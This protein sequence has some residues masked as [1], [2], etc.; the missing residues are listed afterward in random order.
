MKTAVT[1]VLLALLGACSREQPREIM[2]TV[3]RDR[4]ELVAESNERIVEIR[5]RE[6]DRVAVDAI[7][8]VQEAGTIQPRLEQAQAVKT[9]AE[10]NLADLLAG[11]RSREI[12]EARAALAGAE[13]A[14][15]TDVA[16][17]E[18]VDALVGRKLLSASELDRA[19]AQ[20]DASR[21]TRDAARSRLELLREGT[22]AEQIAAARAAVAG[23]EA[24]LAEVRTVAD[25]YTVRA[26]RAGIVE[27]LPYELGERPAAGRAVAILLADGAPFARVYVPEP[28]RTRFL[29]GAR[30][31]VR[32]DGETAPFRGVVRYVA[33]EAAFTPYYSLTQ[34]DRS[35]L[36]YLAEVTL[37]E[38]E[39]A[40]LP[41]GVPVQVRLVDDA[42]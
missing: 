41:A 26:P 40:R 31:E 12:E 10:R 18:R 28:L 24:A 42:P 20:R 35:R 27:A 36:A 2:G 39:A 37:D 1:V 7:L 11:P 25:R 17:Y 5:V 4:L 21:A 6:G 9:E 3:E 29:P 14:M 15:R 30:V 33:A 19:R 34:K 22:R 8:V 16:E 32:V 13:S 23:A 38:P